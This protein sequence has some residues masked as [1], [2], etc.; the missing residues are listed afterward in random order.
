LNKRHLIK[1]DVGIA[2]KKGTK[3]EGLREAFHMEQKTKFP[4]EPGEG[5]DEELRIPAKN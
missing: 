5:Q 2:G 1:G 4:W 3:Q